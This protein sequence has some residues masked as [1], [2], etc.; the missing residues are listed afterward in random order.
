[1]K[2]KVKAIRSKFASAAAIAMGAVY[3]V[4][5]CAP[6][7]AGDVDVAKPDN[8]NE[9][10]GGLAWVLKLTV[11]GS[12]DVV[13]TVGTVLGVLLKACEYLGA[14]VLL[15]GLICW[16][17]AM[18]NEDAGSKQKAMMATFTGILLFTLKTILTAAGIIV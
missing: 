13:E 10:G 1:M 15:W 17:M 9:G 7:Y 12:T 2:K 4:F 11:P 16:I 8:G 3:Q 5:A 14:A 18:K 6:V